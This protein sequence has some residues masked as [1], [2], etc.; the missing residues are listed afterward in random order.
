M[1]WPGLVSWVG[2][3]HRDNL[4]APFPLG[5]SCP[6]KI[7]MTMTICPRLPVPLVWELKRSSTSFP[8]SRSFA[9]LVEKRRRH[10]WQV[11]PQ[12][13]SDFIFFFF[14]LFTETITSKQ[15]SQK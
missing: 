11:I 6:R 1:L 10:D 9:S 3:L 2:A 7:A 15:C 5:Q 13:T 4:I 8:G 14:A 12:M